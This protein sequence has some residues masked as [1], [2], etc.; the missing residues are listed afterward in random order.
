MAIKATIFKANVQLSD[1][2]RG[3]YADY[4]VVIARHPSEIHIAAK[5]LCFKVDFWPVDTDVPV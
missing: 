1:I 3:H 4:P 2:D 5:R